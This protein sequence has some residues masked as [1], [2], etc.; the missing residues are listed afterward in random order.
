[1]FPVN[2]P[3]LQNEANR[4]EAKNQSVR[5]NQTVFSALKLSI[6]NLVDTVTEIAIYN[7]VHWIGNIDRWLRNQSSANTTTYKRGDIVFLDLGAQNFKH[8]PSYTHA[9]IVLANRFDSILIVPCSTKQYGTGHQGIIDATPRDGFVK[10]TGI[11]TENF[12][13]VSKNRVVS[14]T[15]NKVSSDV[16]N[17][18][19]AVLL[20]FSPAT[21]NL[22]AQKDAKIKNQQEEIESLK[23]Q[24]ESA[25]AEI[26]KLTASTK[27]D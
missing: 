2:I 4:A 20:S 13:W 15:G 11:Q 10:N 26:A 21:K 6:V 25:N 7:A 3:S 24:L 8:E 9:C 12:R 19:D 22:I 23:N 1:M 27:N 5:T 18:L 17:K 16:L 14:N